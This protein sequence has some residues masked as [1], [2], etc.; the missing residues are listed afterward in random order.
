MEQ[1][2]VEAMQAGATDFVLKPFDIDRFLDTVNR[3][4]AV[5]VTVKGSEGTQTDV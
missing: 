3:V 2:V 4:L 5:T 1:S